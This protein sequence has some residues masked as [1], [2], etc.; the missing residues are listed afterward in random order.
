MELGFTC[1][2]HSDCFAS[3]FSTFSSE[4]LEWMEE[5]GNLGDE[6]SLDRE[7]GSVACR[8]R[9]SDGRSEGDGSEDELSLE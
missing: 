6:L 1:W 3:T 8:S 9:V 4:I 7:A 2:S 5:N